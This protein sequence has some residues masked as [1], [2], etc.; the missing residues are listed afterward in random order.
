MQ[1][2]ALG[3]QAVKLATLRVTPLSQAKVVHMATLRAMVGGEEIAPVEPRVV[4]VVPQREVVKAAQE[5][6]P[7][8]VAGADTHQVLGVTARMVR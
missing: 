8:A 2:L 1:P 4:V 5:P 7:E 6:N 3:E